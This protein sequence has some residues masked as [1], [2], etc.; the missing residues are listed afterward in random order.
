M[1]LPEY[2][3]GTFEASYDEEQDR[4]LQKIESDDKDVFLVTVSDLTKKPEVKLDLSFCSKPLSIEERRRKI[5]ECVDDETDPKFK[6]FL[7]FWEK[8]A[9]AFYEEQEVSVNVDM[10]FNSVRCKGNGT[11]MFNGQPIGIECQGDKLV[12]SLSDTLFSHIF[13][14][15]AKIN[16]MV[17]NGYC[18]S[19]DAIK[20]ICALYRMYSAQEN[21][22]VDTYMD[23]EQ[24]GK[25]NIIVSYPYPRILSGKGSLTD[26]Q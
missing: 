7:L 3:N 5:K 16:E 17:I 14:L 11:I 23:K 21:T 22:F 18:K 1:G 6:K 10:S 4:L 25:L 24:D 9:D 15:T 20:D 2:L 26:S 13:N 19:D 8:N 12:I